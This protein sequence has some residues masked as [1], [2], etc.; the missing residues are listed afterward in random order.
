L[1][2]IDYMLGKYVFVIFLSLYVIRNFRGT[3]SSIKMLKEYMARVSLGTP[4][5]VGIT[6]LLVLNQ[7]AESN[8][9]VPTHRAL[10]NI[11]SGLK[12]ARNHEWA[13]RAIASPP[14]YFANKMASTYS[15]LKG[16]FSKQRY[17]YVNFFSRQ[18]FRMR[19]RCVV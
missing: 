8:S 14:E 18:L 11:S 15:T 1:L 2:K 9:N 19:L 16:Y 10:E 17:L 3:R 4:G 12:Q 6:S 13:N 7:N 5:L